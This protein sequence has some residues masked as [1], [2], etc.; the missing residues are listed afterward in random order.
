MEYYNN[1]TDVQSTQE[2]ILGG[3]LYMKHTGSWNILAVFLTDTNK[4]R[5]TVYVRM[6]SVDNGI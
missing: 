6:G 4:L 5:P 2:W 3:A 1:G